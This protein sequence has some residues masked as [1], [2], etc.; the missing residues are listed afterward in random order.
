MPIY[1]YISLMGKLI[2]W[3]GII[4][5][6]IPIVRYLLSFIR[7]YVKLITSNPREILER[8][9]DGWKRLLE[10]LKKTHETFIESSKKIRKA[11]I[12]FLEK[13]YWFKD[14]IRRFFK[15]R[16]SDEEKPEKAEEKTGAKDNFA[17]FSRKDNRDPISVKT[18]LDDDEAKRLSKLNIY[19]PKSIFKKLQLDYVPARLYKMCERMD[20]LKATKKYLNS[21]NLSLDNLVE[22]TDARLWFNEVL[23][24]IMIMEGFSIT[25]ELSDE[26]FY[27]LLEKRG[28]TLGELEEVV[29]LYQKASELKKAV[30]SDAIVFYDFVYKFKPNVTKKLKRWGSITSKELDKIYEK[31]QFFEEHHLK[32]LQNVEDIFDVIEAMKSFDGD[33]HVKELNNQISHVD[34]EIEGI[35]KGYIDLADA[36]EVLT[37][38]CDIL[39]ALYRKYEHSSSGADDTSEEEAEEAEDTSSKSSSEDT[40]SGDTKDKDADSGS[41]GKTYNRA[42]DWFAHTDI[43]GSGGSKEGCLKVLGLD[44]SETNWEVVQTTFKKLANKWH[45]DK[46]DRDMS[47]EEKKEYGD[48]LGE[49]IKSYQKLRSTYK[50]QFK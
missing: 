44:K 9:K 45:P 17:P 7:E 2:L 10:N 23:E 4:L 37:K 26:P 3:V 50:K 25:S 16:P 41:K 15:W 32:Y 47:E 5:I 43:S 34:K 27:A 28:V 42:K 13:W 40:S 48:V 49:I 14:K 18:A 12:T 38:R 8:L 36:D 1:F 20:G 21:I 35:K 19:V 22:S 31:Y 46:Q 33:D 24:L 29:E 30:N 11:Y 39:E 6:A